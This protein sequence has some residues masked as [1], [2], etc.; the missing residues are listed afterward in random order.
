MMVPIAGET[1]SHCRW[2]AFTLQVTTI[3]LECERPAAGGIGVIKNV[4]P[5]SLR[6]GGPEVL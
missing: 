1:F 4:R 5:I 2:K 3:L 6:G